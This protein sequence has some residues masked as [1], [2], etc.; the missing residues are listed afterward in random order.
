MIAACR[1]NGVKL[2]VAY[3]RRFYPAVMRVKAIIESGE[4]GA[5]VFAQMNA[6]ER[7]D[8][9]PDRSALRGC[10]SRPSPAAGR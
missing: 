1:A 3:Y 2:G 5:P 7:F 8:P 4:I 10:C 6:F 9:P